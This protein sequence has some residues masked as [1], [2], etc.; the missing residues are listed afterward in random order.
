MSVQSLKV[1]AIIS[2]IRMDVSCLILYWC[3]YPI[4]PSNCALWIWCACTLVLY[5]RTCWRKILFDWTS[6]WRKG[7][8]FSWK[9]LNKQILGF[10]K[11]LT[12]LS[13]VPKGKLGTKVKGTGIQLAARACLLFLDRI[14]IQKKNDGKEYE[15]VEF[16]FQR[17]KRI[18]RNMNLLE[19]WIN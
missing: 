11:L 17:W 16:M 10:Q 15:T 13:V 12:T 1:Q 2:W 7:K 9:T 14:I 3:M 18:R 6:N 4:F 8:N 19:S 5:C